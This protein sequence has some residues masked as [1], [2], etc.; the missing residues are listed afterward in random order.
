MKILLTAF[1]AFGGETAN[2][3]LE[4]VRR[5]RAPRGVALDVLELPTVFASCAR[6]AA[7][8]MQAQHPDIVLCTGQASGRPQL[9]LERIAINLDDARIPD[10]AGM[11]PVEQPI[12]PGGPA[13]YF[14]T[15]PL[16]SLCQA[17]HAAGF[18]CAVSN[19]AGTFVCNHLLYNVLDF[20]A[21]EM[22]GVRAGFIHI[23]CTPVQAAHMH[24]PAPSMASA[25]AA[26][27][28]EVIL[29]ALC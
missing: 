26:Q 24:P 21:R 10:N 14:T 1:E 25:D 13:A 11:Q 6:I 28:L 19:T 22:P 7:A 20:A 27:A 18:P 5:V 15:L 2:A 29:A 16:Q 12:C 3:A 4:A 9:T 17:V 23:P 8:A